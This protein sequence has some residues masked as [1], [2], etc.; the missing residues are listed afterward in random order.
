P[1]L[2]V[3]TQPSG[4]HKIDPRNVNVRRYN[5]GVHISIADACFWDGCGSALSTNWAPESEPHCAT[6]LRRL[7]LRPL[8]ARLDCGAGSS[9]LMLAN[10]PVTPGGAGS[11]PVRS[12]S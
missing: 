4:Y 11:S 7:P 9:S 5:S 2:D 10:R 8:H 1:I 12:A 6:G 3:R